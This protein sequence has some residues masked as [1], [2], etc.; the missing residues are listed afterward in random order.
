MLST[1]TVPE[2]LANR[3]LDSSILEPLSEPPDR[4]SIVVIGAGVAG[5][6]V[7]YH[8]TKL[9]ITDVVVLERTRLTGEK[10]ESTQITPISLSPLEFS[11]AVR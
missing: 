8:L 9:G 7:A 5:S 3:E 10:A 2:R 1:M 6:S 4:A 11:S